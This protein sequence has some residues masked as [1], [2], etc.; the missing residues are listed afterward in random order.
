MWEKSGRSLRPAG[1]VALALAVAVLGLAGRALIRSADDGQF[2]PHGTCYLWDP[3][4]VW[5]H[6]ISDGLI[7][8][9][10]F[11]IPIGLI[12][13]VRQRR[14][15]PFNW[16]F[17]MFGA[18]IVGCGITH[19]MEIWTIWHA[20]YLLAGIIKAGT[21]VI[22]VITAIMMIPLIPKAIALPSPAQLR[23]ANEGLQN[24]IL[25]REQITLQLRDSLRQREATLALLA[26][27]QTAVEE[28]QLVEAAL[29]ESQ[30]R[31]NAIIQ[32]AMDAIIA[33][34]G[35][36]NVLIFNAAAEKM[37]GYT[38]VEAVGL[39][40]QQFIPERF[41]PAHGSHI[42]NF[43]E[44]GRGL[45]RDGEEFPLEASISQ[46][47]TSG[48]KF[49]TVILRDITERKRAEE[50]RERLAAIVD[51]SDDAIICK[52]LGGIVTAWNASAE[53]LFGYPAAEAIGRPMP[54]LFPPDRVGEE[55]DI[56]NR[57]AKGESI[58]HYETV[59]TRKD[60]SPV[61]VS[62]TVSPIRDH[63]GT[64]VGVSKIARDI[65]ARKESEQKLARKAE[66]LERKAEELAR[67]NR[68]LEQF[69][70][71]ASH[72]LQEPLRMVSSYTQLLSERYRGQLDPSADKFI[73]YV[74]DGAQRMQVMIQDLLAFSRIGHPGVS[75][76]VVDCNELM[77]GVL[78]DLANAIQES[79]ATINFAA[80]P[81]VCADRVHVVQLFQ[82]L[83]GN[84]IKFRS[85]VPLEIAVSAQKTGGEWLFSIGDNGIGISPEHS[86][87]IFVVFQRLHA[88]TEYPGNGIGL[89][90][91]KKIVE[92]Y[93]G[94][95]WVEARNGG[96]STFN[97][98]LPAAALE[99]P[100][101]LSKQVGASQ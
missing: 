38:A 70:Y 85:K 19:F 33:V 77:A 62:V 99:T 72:D 35:C 79:G 57:L 13:L 3:K 68:E 14:D 11:C 5:L 67:S 90:I 66:E 34:D 21:A 51:S 42:R 24:E 86:Q 36:W 45:R 48:K 59:R 18:F 95:I 41:R 56:L 7:T 91:C 93:Y 28:L 97:F 82:N 96:G 101:R 1:V 84:A 26:D 73:G 75:P 63:S 15:L 30:G 49:F 55:L 31:L 17:W 23:S 47:E 44:T 71:V 54:M 32:S 60:G 27:R 92:Q 69:A 53:R 6:V 88:R 22:S 78:Q 100:A 8:L 25:E 65:S 76:E 37:F 50:A 89:A 2:L 74:L 9:S 29:S 81:S 39:S 46:V 98:T 87:N 83:I 20:S 80:L 58:K 61:E 94:K 4:I 16:I 64:I 40:I 43:G 12:Y 52:A 10:Y